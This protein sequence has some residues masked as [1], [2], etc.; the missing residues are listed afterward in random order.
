[1]TGAFLN[2][3]GILLGGIFGL[4]LRKPISVRAQI[5]FRTG[6]GAVAVLFGL[7]L[8]Y[9]NIGG[10]FSLCLKQVFL[11]LL[12][13]VLGFWLGKLLGLQKISN[14]LGRIAGNS[15]ASAQKNLPQKSSAGF[16]A[17]AIL[18]CAASLGL[19]GA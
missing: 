8:I 2:A 17:C 10:T 19:L 9:E 18:F 1:M 11:A 12:A 6:L 16:N 3:I 15:I 7:R 14:R 4:A 5:F 13:V